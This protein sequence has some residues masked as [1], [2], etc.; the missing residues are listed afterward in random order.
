MLIPKEYYL[1]PGKD[2]PEGTT[3]LKCSICGNAYAV[4]TDIAIKVGEAQI[5]DCE[6]CKEAAEKQAAA[7]AQ[8]LMKPADDTQKT[9]DTALGK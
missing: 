8:A 2:A 9:I 7:E 5:C 6:E 4:P 3:V 1:E